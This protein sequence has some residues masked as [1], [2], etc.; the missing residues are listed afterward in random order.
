MASDSWIAV[1]RT[2]LIVGLCTYLLTQAS[3]V[4]MHVCLMVG[5]SCQVGEGSMVGGNRLKSSGKPT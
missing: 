3:D 5:E 4:F 2:V 1:S